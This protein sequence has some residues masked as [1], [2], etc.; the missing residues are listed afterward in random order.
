LPY[1]NHPK[2]IQK[3][4]HGLRRRGFNSRPFFAA[5]YGK[6]SIQ[7]DRRKTQ[8]YENPKSLFQDVPFSTVP[9]CFF[10]GTYSEYDFVGL[11]GGAVVPPI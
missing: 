4:A 11:Q 7:R 10:V 9:T 8:C 3:H 1:Q 6:F 2:N 5:K